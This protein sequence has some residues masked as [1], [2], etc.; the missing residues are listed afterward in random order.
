[1]SE[2][3]HIGISK[4][5]LAELV[6]GKTI[7]KRPYFNGSFIFKKNNAK[8]YDGDKRIWVHVIT[9]RMKRNELDE[10]FFIN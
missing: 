6:K 1:M 5:Q 8:R 10:A 7:G 2:D 4:E 3:L 9:D